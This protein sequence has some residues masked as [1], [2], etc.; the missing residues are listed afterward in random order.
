MAA[1]SLSDSAKDKIVAAKGRVLSIEELMS[2]NPS[3]S[4]VKILG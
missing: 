1:L 4:K 3:G 2:K